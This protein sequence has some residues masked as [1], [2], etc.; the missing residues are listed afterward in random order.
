MFCESIDHLYEIQ[1]IIRKTFRRIRPKHKVFEV[2]S[3]NSISENKIELN[4]FSN[5]TPNKNECFLMFAVDMLNE[6]IHVDG[7][8][9]VMLFRKTES[10]RLYFQQIGRAIRRHGVKIP[11]IFDCVLNYQSVK[12]NFGKELIRAFDKRKNSLKKLGL[13]TASVPRDI[14]VFGWKQLEFRKLL[15]K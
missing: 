14:G 6:G 15:R 9:A 3:C 5:H 4:S 7:I 1:P 12:V 11:L 8:D 10:P 13:N 2:Y